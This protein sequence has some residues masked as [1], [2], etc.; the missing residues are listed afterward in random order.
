MD[1]ELRRPY[2]VYSEVIANV[3]LSSVCYCDQYAVVAIPVT[4]VLFL[5]VLLA[6]SRQCPMLDRSK[7]LPALHLTALQ[8]C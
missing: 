8:E 6:L 7:I 2:A 4:C 5:G 3:L 1:L